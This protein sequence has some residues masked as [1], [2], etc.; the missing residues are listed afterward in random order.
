MARLASRWPTFLL[1]LALGLARAAAWAMALAVG[2]AAFG[3]PPGTARVAEAAAAP[4]QV[5]GRADIRVW[6]AA[7]L[8]AAPG[9]H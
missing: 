5:D 2:L 9:D 4:L 6:P 7:T 8:R 3:G 1:G